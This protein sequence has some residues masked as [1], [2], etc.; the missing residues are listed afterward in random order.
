MKKTISIL[1]IVAMMLASLLAIVPAYAAEPEGTAITNEKEFLAMVPD[2]TY[3][4]ANDITIGTAYNEF[5]G[6]LDG[7]GKTVRLVGYVSMFDTLIQARI[8]NLNIVANFT[9][10]SAKTYG[11]LAIRASGNFTNIHA[12]VNMIF[13]KSGAGDFTHMWGGIFAELDGDATLTNCSSTGAISMLA[14]G[15]TIDVSYSIGGLVGAARGSNIYMF[16]KCTNFTDVQSRKHRTSNGGFVGSVNDNGQITFEECI[17]YGSI[18]GMTGG[19]GGSA[20]FVGYANGKH[21]TSSSYIFLNCRNYGDI[22]DIPNPNGSKQNHALGGMVGRAISPTVMAF[23]NCVNSGT[24]TNL[25]GGW[26]TAGG[27]V[28]G[29]MSYNI[30]STS[31]STKGTISFKNCVNVG[32]IKGANF[33]GGITGGILQV[34]SSD[35][36]ATFENCSNYG[37]TSGSGILGYSGEDGA[38]G[39]TI[40]N[41]YNAGTTSNSG[42]LGSYKG[43]F[44]P[45]YASDKSVTVTRPP[46]SIIGCVNEGTTQYAIL[47][48]ASSFD[49]ITITGC[50]TTIAN[51]ELALADDAIIVSDTPEN[52]ISAATDLRATVPANTSA[53]D[54]IVAKNKDN[55][56]VDYTAGWGKFEGALEQALFVATRAYTQEYVDL[57]IKD[58]NTAV[59][60]LVFNENIDYTALESVLTSA[61]EFEGQEA[62][63]TKNSWSEFVA[64][65]EAAERLTNA[66]K[67]SEVNKA[68]DA[69]SSAINALEFKPNF[70][71]L[72]E[73]IAKYTGLTESEYVTATWIAFS[74]ALNAA[75]TIEKNENATGTQINKALTNLV[76]AAEALAKKADVA[77]LQAKY[78]KTLADYSREDYTAKSYVAL[79]E[80][81]RAIEDAIASADISADDI[82]KLIAN[83]DTAIS[84]LTPVADFTELKALLDQY[85]GLSSQDYTSETWSAFEEAYLAATNAMSPS[86]APNVSVEEGAQLTAALISAHDALLSWADYTEIDALIAEILTLNSNDYTPESWQVVQTAISDAIALKSNRNATVID[87]EAALKKLKEAKDALSLSI[88]TP[89]ET[90]PNDDEQSGCGSFAAT[91]AV[92]IT[93]VSILGSAIVMKKRSNI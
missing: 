1:L 15:G 82:A 29:I 51:Q 49:T 23:E 33:T 24:I 81:L 66:Q 40:K 30:S 41:C 73:E 42:I 21:T 74:E 32:E 87:S 43:A 46:V 28:A 58:L 83:V 89:T 47:K 59:A 52:A 91:S 25:G 54:A 80:A 34:N 56:A 67:Q 84:K 63:Y 69:L 70:D 11:T 75:Q 72:R 76:E 62:L 13:P 18:S 36:S 60:G 17:N 48:G 27:I 16:K 12:D 77:P 78:D 39:L 22:T 38:L 31:K 64:A 65:L 26:A 44:S 71:L 61:A 8:S 90:L 2:G 35:C 4:L 53:L 68:A 79:T 20:G 88:N 55:Q 6:T 19:H 5:K 9:A 7:N 86:N 85:A 37:E 45:N 50:A 92:V 57:A 93:V 14:E 10:D 3:Y